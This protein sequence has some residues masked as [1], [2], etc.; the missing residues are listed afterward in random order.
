[1]EPRVWSFSSLCPRIVHFSKKC[2]IPLLLSILSTSLPPLPGE[3]HYTGASVPR[4]NQPR[5]WGPDGAAGKDVADLA[6]SGP[7]F[8]LPV[9]WVVGG[10]DPNE[11]IVPTLKQVPCACPVLQ[12]AGSCYFHFTHHTPAFSQDS[13]LITNHFLNLWI[14]WSS[15]HLFFIF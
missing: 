1:M 4:R 8:C 15:A 6:F 14:S 2:S 13:Y 7:T 12:Y 10:P 5:S 3:A 9:L 11:S